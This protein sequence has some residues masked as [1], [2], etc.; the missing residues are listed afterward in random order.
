MQTDFI[1]FNLSTGRRFTIFLSSEKDWNKEILKLQYIL[2]CM[3]AI[4]ALILLLV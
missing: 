2:Y 3:I 4:T 1:T